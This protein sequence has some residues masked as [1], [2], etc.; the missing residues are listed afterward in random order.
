MSAF[1]EAG[2]RV[3]PKL[4]PQRRE[5][6]TQEL[7]N[8]LAYD[9]N[10]MKRENAAKRVKLVLQGMARKLGLTGEV[11]IFG[12]FSNGFK[13]GTSD[14]DI[15][16][17]AEPNIEQVPILKKFA[18]LV[19]DFGF[20]HVTQIFSANVPLL[21]FT[22]IKAQMEVDFCV[23]NILGVRNSSLLHAYCRH[24]HRA[25]RLGRLVKQWAKRRQIVGTADGCLNNYAY[26]LLVIYFLQVITPCVVV[27]LQAEAKNT[28]PVVD[29]KWGIEDTWETKFVDAVEPFPKSRNQL[30]TAELLLQFF[31]YYTHI[32][33]WRGQAVC[34]R[35][36][37][38]DAPVSKL[39]ISGSVNLDQW[40]IE[41]PFDLKH[42]L[43]GKCTRAAKQRI[44]DGMRD[45][46]A[47][48]KLNGK[49]ELAA[50]VEKPNGYYL[51]SRISASVT[52]QALLEE[53]EDT[54]LV[55]LYFPKYEAGM[56]RPTV[57]F[58]FET[59]YSRRR[60]HSKNEKFVADYQLQ[61]HQTAEHSLAEAMSTQQ[62]S[63]YEMAS[64]RMQLHVMAARAKGEAKALG[65]DMNLYNYYP[66]PGQMQKPAGTWISPVS[67]ASGVQTQ[68]QHMTV[69][70]AQH[71]P[72]MP[73][74]Q[75]GQSSGNKLLQQQQQKQ[76]LRDKQLQQQQQQRQWQAQPEQNQKEQQQQQKQRMLKLKEEQQQNRPW[77]LTNVAPKKSPTK[78]LGEEPGLR[79]DAEKTAITELLRLSRTMPMPMPRV[80][81]MP[82]R[83][84]PDRPVTSRLQDRK[85]AW[86]EVTFDLDPAVQSPVI[87]DQQ[88]KDLQGLMEFT[89]RYKPAEPVQLRTKQI[90]Q[91]PLF[92]PSPDSPPVVKPEHREDL[93][94]FFHWLEKESCPQ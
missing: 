17:L 21:K 4:D 63:T 30:T 27:N 85:A 58:E 5:Q 66:S 80:L 89:R 54:N 9:T 79:V 42:N 16:F 73:D 83:L 90:M 94:K 92:S 44:L 22:D 1:L 74:M 50:P 37:G 47:T 25:L 61:L 35:L 20:E 7:A 39:S 76:Q 41:D 52:P 69:Q 84:E 87:T 18:D 86:L 28:V 71:V 15:V 59:S 81:A 93:I 14:L 34:V 53:F 60:A 12:S 38:E 77:L 3:P 45:A 29:V 91:L 75:D 88:V 49:W 48:L 8:A 10:L 33:D 82:T 40:L 57:F 32:F 36:A 65:Y 51:K 24:D 55:K 2:L 26:M 78:K 68:A 70:Q 46:L 56:G 72:P 6:L 62:F 11:Q 64:Y 31:H 19:T 23:N 13:T 67:S 43:A